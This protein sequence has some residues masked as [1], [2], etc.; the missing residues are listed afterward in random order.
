MDAATD[1]EETAMRDT[2]DFLYEAEL[3]V[4][5]PNARTRKAIIRCIDP[6]T[7]QNLGYT[8]E[9]PLLI[10]M[11]RSTS[12]AAILGG[13]GWMRVRNARGRRGRI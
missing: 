7:Q 8:S 2:L 4:T 3:L 10:L 12:E 9:S 6:M 13:S 1:L 5:P 11:I